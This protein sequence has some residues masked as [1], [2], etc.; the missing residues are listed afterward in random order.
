[1][2]R[3]KKLL[4]SLQEGIF[5]AS[6]KYEYSYLLGRSVF[7]KFLAILYIY[8]LSFTLALLSVFV[9]L[10]GLLNTNI[11]A[12]VFLVLIIP[13][14]LYKIFLNSQVIKEFSMRPTEKEQSKTI[15]LYY[16]IL[17]LGYCSFI[18][19]CVAVISSYS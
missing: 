1:M 10:K 2:E 14:I 11:Y 13:Y 19:S 9:Q 6:G 17:V 7:I 12:T 15:K 3:F 5:F 16:I 4:V 8:Y 18:T